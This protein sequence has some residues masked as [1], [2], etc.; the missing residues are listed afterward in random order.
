MQK[1][2]PLRSPSDCDTLLKLPVNMKMEENDRQ[3]DLNK[4]FYNYFLLSDLVTLNCRVN[5]KS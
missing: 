3:K 2:K 5:P 4:S 1:G